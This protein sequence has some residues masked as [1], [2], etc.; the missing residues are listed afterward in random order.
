MIQP[1]SNQS[2]PLRTQLAEVYGE[3]LTEKG[4]HMVVILQGS[5]YNKCDWKGITVYEIPS[6]QV[7]KQVQTI[8]KILL[9]EKCNILQIRNSHLDGLVALFLKHVLNIPLVYQYTFP[10]LEYARSLKYVSSKPFYIK[11]SRFLFNDALQFR[12]MH[13]SD[14]VLAMSDEMGKYLISRNV[15][16]RKIY[17]F[18]SGAST[19]RY[20]INSIGKH[21]EP[22]TFPLVTYIGAMSIMRKLEFL[23]ESISVVI[24][25]N[26][27]VQFQI[28]GDGDDRKHLERQ[29]RKLGVEE[30]V[31]FT[32]KV[33]Y[34]EIPGILMNSDIGVSPIPPIPAYFLSSP[35]KIYEYM[36]AGLPVVANTGIPDQEQTILRSGGGILVPY[37]AYE[38]GQGI[39]KLASDLKK[40]D[41]IGSKGRSWVDNNRSYSKIALYIESVLLTLIDDGGAA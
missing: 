33:P 9:Q 34:T 18:P 39:L 32:G 40:A 4:H 14:L 25:E 41:I 20:D 26:P 37:D 1:P 3:H 6:L 22:R 10:S 12:C 5:R 38:F 11:K 15:A 13:G 7:W 19:D 17:T 30:N 29:S 24:Q 23:I 35:L 8:R 27:S 28:V 21:P 2:I 36:A 31:T 16:E